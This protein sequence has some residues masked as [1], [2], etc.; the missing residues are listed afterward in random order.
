[1]CP[2]T[3]TK[4]CYSC[5]DKELTEYVNYVDSPEGE[6][7]ICCNDYNTDVDVSKLKCNHIFHNTCIKTWL[8]TSG[9]CPICRNNVF[10]CDNCDG[11]GIIRYQYTGAVIPISERGIYLNRNT[12]DGLFGIR[13]YDL[14]DLLIETLTYDRTK[15][16]LYVNIIS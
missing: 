3:I 9:T 2:Y 7:C 10:E 5:I 13:E 1:M 16:R 12:T 4:Y 14:E 6:C 8:S 15:K 11:T